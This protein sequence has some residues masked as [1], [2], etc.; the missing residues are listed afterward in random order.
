MEGFERR[1]LDDVDWVD[2]VPEGL[3]HLATVSVADHGVAEDF[4]E[5]HL[6]GEVDAEE[7]HTSDPEEQNV[8]AGLEEVRGVELFEVGRLFRFRMRNQREKGNRRRMEDEPCQAIPGSRKA[9]DRKRTRCRGRPRPAR[10]RT[11][12]RGTS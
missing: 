12:C 1:P 4:G 2:D 6:A 7:D 3:G 5:G 10:E 8:P 11:S 9:K